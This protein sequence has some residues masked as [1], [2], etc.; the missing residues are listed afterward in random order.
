MEQCL[1][2]M[3]RCFFEPLPSESFTC[4]YAYGETFKDIDIKTG[5]SPKIME[6]GFN[7]VPCCR[8]SPGRS[9]CSPPEDKPFFIPYIRQV[10][11]KY[12]LKILANSYQI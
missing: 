8:F 6:H 1:D 7:E 12:L 4:C 9:M 10:G 5:V 3:H 11:E 2:C